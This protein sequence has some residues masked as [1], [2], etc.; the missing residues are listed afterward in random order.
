MVE[1]AVAGAPVAR[2]SAPLLPPASPSHQRGRRQR[3]ARH[4]PDPGVGSFH[5][6]QVQALADAI[7]PAYRSL[8]LTAALTGLHWGEPCRAHGSLTRT[9]AEDADDRVAARRAERS[10][11]PGPA[12]DR[13]EPAQYSHPALS[14][15]AAPG[16]PSAA[17]ARQRSAPLFPWK[18]NLKP[19]R[20]LRLQAQVAGSLPPK[21]D[22][23]IHSVLDARSAAPPSPAPANGLD[24]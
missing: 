5:P 1:Q 19:L 21:D 22:T 16:R 12:E 2:E 20:A 8:V 18:R 14:G 24:V 11:P 4:Q 13:G 7:D 17:P 6:E 3:A 9:S 23:L 10:A 15:R